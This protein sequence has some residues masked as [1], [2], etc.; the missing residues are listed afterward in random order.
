[1][2]NATTAGFNGKAPRK[3]LADQLDRLDAI[4]DA[5]AAGLNETVADVV[6]QAVTAAVQ[7]A[8]EGLAQAALSNPDLL[9][10]LTEQ[11][12]P[13]AQEGPA[14]AAVPPARAGW[15]GR[16][17]GWLSSRLSRACGACAAAWRR[18]GGGLSRVRRWLGTVRRFR[19]ELLT[20]VGVGTA[21]GL[22]A[23]FAGPWWRPRWAGW[24]ASRWRWG[25][26]RAWPCAGSRPPP[27][28]PPPPSPPAAP[29]AGP[30][31]PGRPPVSRQTIEVGP[32][33]SGTGCS[34]R[35]A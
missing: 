24:G 26:R 35:D 28:L 9:R 18:A 5:L 32:R 27:T 17:R 29:A 4:I 30:P 34:R 3:T 19:V 22:A 31:R 33:P 25:C 1:M 6:R 13:P 11:F 21:A 8:L 10:R 16:V 12:A 7:Q 14:P 2:T 20:A 15:P 23:Y